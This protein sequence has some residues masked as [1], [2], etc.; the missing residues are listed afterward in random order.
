MKHQQFTLKGGFVLIKIDNNSPKA[1]YE[2]IYDEIAKLILS[3]AVKPD[4][5]LP[6]VREL[7]GLLKISPNTIQKAY[8]FLEMDSYIYTVRGKGNFV[9]NTEKLRNIHIEMLKKE[10][11][12]LIGALQRAGLSDDEV[13]KLIKDILDTKN[14][15][16][17]LC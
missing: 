7:A 5:Q 3:G 6:S 16:E 13:L 2:Q 11:F 1:I 15:Q 4:K 12:K 10:L 17:D 9:G 8:R 14:D